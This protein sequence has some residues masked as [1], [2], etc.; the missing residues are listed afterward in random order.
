MPF[1]L[2]QARSSLEIQQP[3]C[4]SYKDFAHLQLQKWQGAMKRIPGAGRGFI[5][6][7]RSM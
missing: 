2:P 6:Y 5:N 7:V 3:P 4:I 1:A